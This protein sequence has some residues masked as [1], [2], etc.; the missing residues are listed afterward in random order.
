LD[1][2]TTFDPRPVA[3]LADRF[4]PEKGV[5]LASAW[6]TRQIEYAW[7]RTLMGRYAPFWQV[8]EEALVFAACMLGLEL[9]PEQRRR[10]MQAHLEIGAWSDA[11]P[12]LEPLKAA[13][14][15]FAFFSNFTAPMLE[16]AGANAGLGGIFEPH[17]STDRVR[18]FKPD[19][20]A[21]RMGVDA[22]GL[23]R[24]E[25]VFAAFGGWDAA[26]AKGFWDP[27]VWESRGEVPGEGRGV[28]AAR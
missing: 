12:A 5:A 28:A 2:F 9:P 18:A 27:A 20:R 8:T 19:P 1:A 7:L 25:I 21:Y 16:A 15:R 13:G 10:L 4:F 24:E 17:L 6:R 11:G 23:A 26:G 3:A 22:F 14:I